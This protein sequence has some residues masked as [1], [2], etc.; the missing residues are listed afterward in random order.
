MQ[1]RRNCQ[2]NK[3]HGSIDSTADEFL[4]VPLLPLFQFQRPCKNRYMD[5]IEH[6]RSRLGRCRCYKIHVDIMWWQ[7]SLPCSWSLKWLCASSW[8]CTC[9]VH[10]PEWV[11][12]PLLDSQLFQASLG[13][14][15][16]L[17][18]FASQPIVRDIP[19]VVPRPSLL[20]NPRY[21]SQK[22]TRGGL[23]PL[24]PQDPPLYDLWCIASLGTRHRSIRNKT[25]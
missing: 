11:A 5:S 23:N 6:K 13:V 8:L 3:C 18:S 19:Q 16:S 1:V 21:T 22:K 7:F 20:L 4:L 2:S 10:V 9:R 12:L 15:T 25:S 17:Y 24:T 14:M